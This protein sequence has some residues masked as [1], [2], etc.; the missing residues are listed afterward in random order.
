M[1]LTKFFIILLAFMS[2]MSCVVVDDG[3]YSAP[4]YRRSPSYPRYRSYPSRPHRPYRPGPSRPI[5]PGPPPRI[6]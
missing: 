5:P 2:L 3:Y 6:R 4:R 1:K